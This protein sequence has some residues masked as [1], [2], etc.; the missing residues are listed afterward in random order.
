M[1]EVIAHFQ[2]NA[3]WYIMGLVVAIPIVAATRKYS[4]PI[5]Q[6]IL[7]TAIYLGLT[8]VVFHFIVVLTKWFKEV[9][10][11]D[12]ARGQESAPLEWQTPLTDFWIKEEYYPVWIYYAEIV[13]VFV[14]VGLVF[15]Y[16][17][18]RFGGRSKKA[19]TAKK[20]PSPY[21]KTKAF[22]KKGRK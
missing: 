2:A 18:M 17:P 15:K 9:S 19:I 11:F 12:R 21:T 4:L 16:R 3:K 8:H 5:L 10:S 1:T 14:I 13:L 20:K 7:E 22:Q 6:Y